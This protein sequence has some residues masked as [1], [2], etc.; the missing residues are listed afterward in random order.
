M[1]VYFIDPIHDSRW[2]EL[3]DRHPDGSVFHS[4]AWLQALRNTYGYDCLALTTAA[5][6]EPLSDGLVACRVQ[7]WLTGARI[8]SLPFADHCEPL[9]DSIS[10]LQVFINE[11][12]RQYTQPAWRYIELR[13]INALEAL[14]GTAQSLSQ[15][16][17]FCCHR[18]DL[19]PSLEDL[20]RAFHKS[21]IQRKLERAA[22]EGLVIEHGQSESLLLN[23]YR[24]LLITRRRHQLP[25]QP[26][27]WFRN[28]MESFG[29]ALNI[30]VA[31]KSGQPVAAIL[32]LASRN[33]VVYKYG[34]SDAA[35]HPL[36]AMPALFWQAIQY[37]KERNA[38]CF[39][40]GRSD[41]NN[42]GLIAFK[43]HWGASR[44]TLHYY[45]DVAASATRASGI[46]SSTFARHCV[47]TLP[48]FCLAAAGRL[49]Y[50]HMG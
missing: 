13:P 17:A 5:P 48:D 23:L 14:P 19:S 41:L 37:A 42:P 38:T 33:T 1:T 7:S 50:R 40:F 10:T 26:L 2:R 35:F 4:P 24:L 30:W 21:C 39:D 12:R 27:A 20:Y 44:S 45:R 49:L 47:S 28:L 29:A 18:L 8:V 3:L 34:C 32:T 6:S 22:R 46:S 11:L 31:S 16:A 43:D 25:P 36:G 9:V 15:S